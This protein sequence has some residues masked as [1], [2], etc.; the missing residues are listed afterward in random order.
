MIKDVKDLT[1]D[2]DEPDKSE[3]SEDHKI[4]NKTELAQENIQSAPKKK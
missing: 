3:I 4:N 1:D 2:E